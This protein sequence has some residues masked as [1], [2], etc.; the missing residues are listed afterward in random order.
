MKN[1]FMRIAAVTLMLCLVTTCAISGTFAKYTTKEI[2]TDTA[3]VAKW[4]VVI[5]VDSFALFTNQYE[6]DD[7]TATFTGDYSVSSDSD[8]LLAPG[9]S[10]EF[11]EIKI[12][13]TPEVAVAVKVASTVTLSD[14]WIVDGDFYCPLVVTVGSTTIEGINYTAADAFETAIKEAID[15]YSAQYAPNTDLSTINTDLD[16]SWEWAFETGADTAAKEANSKKDTK[17]GDAAVA[18]DLTFAIALT[19]TVDQID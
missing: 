7:D 16:I 8:K 15:D 14:N 12:T 13:G 3:R 11:T 9:T 18:A 4:G 6:T 5:D 10:G 17:L 19:I 1:K 2:G